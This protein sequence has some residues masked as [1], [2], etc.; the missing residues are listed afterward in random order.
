MTR[1]VKYLEYFSEINEKSSDEQYRLK[2]VEKKKLVQK[3]AL[4]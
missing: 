3:M 2:E 1:D 4:L